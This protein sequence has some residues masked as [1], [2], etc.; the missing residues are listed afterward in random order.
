MITEV[1]ITLAA[2]VAWDLG[3]RWLA[4]EVVALQAA[5]EAASKAETAQRAA[6]QARE[7]AAQLVTSAL[8]RVTQL[9]QRVESL[10]LVDQLGAER[11][12]RE[13]ARG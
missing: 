3:R 10:E 2:L 4:R 5:R 11:L 6:E 12:P 1:T 8:E 13:R 9:D 7:A